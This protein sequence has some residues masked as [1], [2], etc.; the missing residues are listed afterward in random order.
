ML[1]EGPKFSVPTAVIPQNLP[2][3]T[4]KINY[5]GLKWYIVKFMWSDFKV[6]TVWTLAPGLA[7]EWRDTLLWLREEAQKRLAKGESDVPITPMEL[8]QA[9]DLSSRAS[10]S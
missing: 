1:V 6:E 3:M 10:G 9:R 4:T 2:N 8:A 5:M 7:L